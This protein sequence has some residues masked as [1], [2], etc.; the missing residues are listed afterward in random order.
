MIEDV[1]QTPVT[2]VSQNVPGGGELMRFVWS[3]EAGVPNEITWPTGNYRCQLDVSAAGS[4]V[5]YGLLT[6][7]AGLGHFARINAGLTADV[8]TK[9]QVEAAATGTGL[10]LFTTGSVSW[11]DAAAL[12]RFE[13]LVSCARA[14]GHGNQS[15]SIDVGEVDHFADGPWDGP[16]A[17]PGDTPFFGANA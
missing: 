2:L 3:T 9:Q 4:E 12:D 15:I 1:L 10:N 5:T 16:D 8:E 13:C 17:V 7:G 14:G 6:Q 11:A